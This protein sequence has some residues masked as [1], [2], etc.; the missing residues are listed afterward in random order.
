MTSEA[1]TTCTAV[2]VLIPFLLYI[3]KLS[4]PLTTVGTRI[5]GNK[6]GMFEF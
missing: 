4:S 2:H 3:K 6:E 1:C 5:V